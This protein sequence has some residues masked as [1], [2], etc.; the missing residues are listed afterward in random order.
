MKLFL[1]ITMWVFIGL[2]ILIAIHS[3]FN[4]LIDDAIQISKTEGFFEF[5]KQ[6]FVEIWTGFSTT[7]G[8]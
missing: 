5:I 3:L 7:F 1:K 4:G 8:F 6:F 2:F